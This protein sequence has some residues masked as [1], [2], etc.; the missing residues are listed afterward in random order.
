MF[1]FLTTYQ[2]HNFQERSFLN[3]FNCYKKHSQVLQEHLCKQHRYLSNIFLE[4]NKYQGIYLEAFLSSIG[5][6]MKINL[7]DQI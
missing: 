5:G 1:I 7:L 3:I 6:L 2:K 4:P